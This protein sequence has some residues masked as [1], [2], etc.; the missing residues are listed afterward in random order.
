MRRCRMVCTFPGGSP[1]AAEPALAPWRRARSPTDA[2]RA[3][4]TPRGSPTSAM[5]AMHRVQNTRRECPNPWRDAACRAAV[6][7]LRCPPISLR[8]ARHTRSTAAGRHHTQHERAPH[9]GVLGQE[10]EGGQGVGA[11]QVHGVDGL[12]VELVVVRRL[13]PLPA[14]RVQVRLQVSGL[15]V[16]GAQGRHC[17]YASAFIAA[18]H[19]EK[20]DSAAGRR[21]LQAGLRTAGR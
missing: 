18:C 11:G 7:P 3:P 10:V 15:H 5:G 8:S 16:S 6:A 4:P 19:V 14:P 21:A 2:W 13:L 9:E 20:A 17:A 1:S 12:Q